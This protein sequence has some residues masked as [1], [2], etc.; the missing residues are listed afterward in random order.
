MHKVCVNSCMALGAVAS[1]SFLSL[2][3]AHTDGEEMRERE[4]LKQAKEQSELLLSRVHELEEQNNQLNKEK[5]EVVTKC[6]AVSFNYIDVFY[7]HD[8]SF[9]MGICFLDTLGELLAWCF[10]FIISK[11]LLNKE[12]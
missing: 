10:S 3:H 12:F 9:Q 4:E 7:Y 6:Q 5:N 2:L 1:Q 11:F 8:I